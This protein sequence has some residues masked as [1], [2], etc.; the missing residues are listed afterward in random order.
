MII[1]HHH[2]FIF[3]RSEKTA[4]TSLERYL[5]DNCKF[6]KDDVITFV[7]GG[8]RKKQNIAGGM[9][10]E[11]PSAYWNHM[12]GYVIRDLLSEEVW[13]TYYKWCV[14]RHPLEKT[15]SSYYHKLSLK[16]VKNFDDYMTGT[17]YFPAARAIM[18]HPEQACNYPKYTEPNNP[19]IVIVDKVIKY[20][21]L[22]RELAVVFKQLNIPWKGKLGYTDK[23][24]YRK[25]KR[26]AV[27]IFEKNPF[28]KHLPK[29]REV[30][31]QE[32]K[33]LGYEF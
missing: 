24:N 4:S 9:S 3:I 25:D 32:I 27:E 15:I 2:K 7:P 12:P 22:N 21:N 17:R 1:N 19:D 23:N 18:G 11:D 6:T 26:P 16:W 33:L 14:D 28:N 5:H 13:T 31:A 30:F 20:E 8:K 29:L 10:E